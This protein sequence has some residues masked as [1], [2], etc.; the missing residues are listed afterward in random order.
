MTEIR[1]IIEYDTSSTH[2]GAEENSAVTGRAHISANAA[3]RL[4][5]GTAAG[6][7]AWLVCDWETEER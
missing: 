7:L 2:Y 4:A 6:A 5:S 1:Q 3:S